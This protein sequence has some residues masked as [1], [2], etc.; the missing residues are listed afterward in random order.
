MIKAFFGH[1]KTVLIHKY[2]VFYY[3]CKLGIP[4]QGI[5][6]DLSKFSWTEFSES[7]KYY[8]GGT[9][10]PIPV[11]KEKNGYSKAWQHHKGRNPH[12]YEYWT[13]NYDSGTTY[14]EIPE[15]LGMKTVGQLEKVR[16]STQLNLKT[17]FINCIQLKSTVTKIMLQRN[18]KIQTAHI[19]HTVMMMQNGILIGVR[20]LKII[21]SFSIIMAALILLLLRI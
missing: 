18:F 16:L 12:H 9:K 2:W 5:T 21:K 11:I 6:H 10:S 13:D 19:S 3:C 7:V 1:L 17:V 4:W 14:I 20:W 15:K 8:Q